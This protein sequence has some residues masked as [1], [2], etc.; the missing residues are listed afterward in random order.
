MA[1]SAGMS[2]GL[3]SVTVPGVTN[4]NPATTTN[5]TNINQILAESGLVS[6]LFGAESQQVQAQGQQ[7]ALDLESQ[8]SLAEAG[9]YTTA[10]GIS[11]ANAQIVGVSGQ[12]QQYQ[13]TRQLMQ[14][15]GSQAADYSANGFQQS[16]TALNVARSSLQ[17]GLLQGQVIGVNTSLEAGGYLE[18]A[19][20]SQAEVVAAQNAANVENTEASTA[21][22]LASLDSS[23]IST[24]TSFLSQIPGITV[25]GTGPNTNITL[26]SNTT[27]KPLGSSLSN[28]LST[29]SI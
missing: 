1:L 20:A 17:Q 25:S 14:T 16:G 28:G 18:Q 22:S 6:A 13:N 7:Q 8:G 24:A 9:A 21:G 23:Q 12:L 11:N 15:L 10:E 27:V 19:A 2:V 26:P 4:T 3:P 5:G 29:T